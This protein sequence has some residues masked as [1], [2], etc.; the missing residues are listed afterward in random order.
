MK[1]CLL[2][3]INKNKKE[4]MNKDLAGGMGTF[5]DFGDSLTSK[6]LSLAKGK[7]VNLPIISFAYLQAILKKKDHFIDYIEGD[8]VSKPYDFVLM[9][10]SIV[11]FK[12]EL[13]ICNKI[14]QKFPKTKVGFFGSFPTTN[15]EIFNKS[16]FAI[17]GEAESFF[18][19]EFK[20][21]K[22]LKKLIRV[23]NLLNLDDLPS[24]DFEN[25]PIKK[26][27]YFPAL[28]EKPFLVLQASK[29]CP[30]SCSYYCPYGS[31]QG[32][33]YR[34][35]SAEKVFEDI[36]QL[37]KKHNVK[38]IQFRDPTFGL[39][40]D[41]VT[42]LCN[43]I[44]KNKVKIRWGVETRLDLLNKNILT[45]MFKAGLRNLNIGIETIDEEIANLN[46]RKIMEIK[47]QEDIVNFCKK[48][49]I[50]I[51]SFYLFGLKGDSTKS[52]KNTIDYAIKLNTNVVQFVISCPYPGTAYY[53]DL[54]SK[55]LILEKDF[56]KFN[57]S[58]LVFKLDYLSEKQLLKLRGYAFRKYYFRFGYI[59]EFLKW[60]L[61]EFW[62]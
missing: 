21:E 20:N 19:Y 62:S 39:N 30:Y 42:K 46:K 32:S 16:D 4:A 18:L 9:Y 23:K 25:F 56:E 35:R 38:G 61:R 14:K 54:N 8:S 17:V 44:I 59:L 5:S 57:S 1:I 31:I 27:S 34:I 28:K 6:I 43:L 22:D 37:I 10:G 29:G 50:K 26:Y 53:N 24:P 7:N 40:K 51:N 47:K 33:K 45:L 36:L 13:R 41:Q 48:I 2:N 3:P 55:G 58:N 12:N 49:G 15:P 60:R 52:I 11:D